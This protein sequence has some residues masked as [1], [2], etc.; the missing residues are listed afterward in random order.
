MIGSHWRRMLLL[1][2]GVTAPLIFGLFGLFILPA[3]AADSAPIP[4][5][6]LSEKRILL[7]YSYHPGF[8]TS[9]Q[10]L[11][12]IR[13]VFGPDGPDVDIEY[14]DAKRVFNKQSVENFVRQLTYKM[15]NLP[16]Y[17]LVMTAD[18]YALRLVLERTDELFSNL[19]VVFF[20]VNNVDL[21]L[22]QNRNPLVTGVV[23]A[24]SF[25][26][27]LALHSSL[28]EER[29]TLN[30]LVDST[31]SGQAD[32]HSL[33]KLVSEFDN[34]NFQVL[35]LAEMDWSQLAEK[36]ALLDKQDAILFLSA[37]QDVNGKTR[38]FKES[39]DFVLNRTEVP[40]WHL[41][42]H[43]VGQGMLGGVLIS[44]YEQGRSA[45]KMA[46][47]VLM[48]EN[49]AN[50]AVLER[51]PN[52]PVF[53]YVLLN[54]YGMDRSRL[55]DSSVILNEPTTIWHIYKLEILL[56][57]VLLSV[58][59]LFTAWLIHKNRQLVQAQG[60]LQSSQDKLRTLSA[61]VEQSPLPVV[62]TSP[63]AF[64]EYVNE[65]FSITTG[66]PTTE[67]IGKNPRIISSG[68]TPRSTY[69]TLWK[70]ISA[71]R[72]WRGELL[73]GRRNG[74]TYWARCVICPVLDERGKTTHYFSIHE[75]ISLQKEQAEK[76]QYQAHY[77]AL[78]DLP[79]RFLVLDRLSQAIHEGRR[80]SLKFALLFIDLDE[81]KTI[82][83]T[84]GHETGDELLKQVARRL[85]LL[86]RKEDTV[87]RLGGD[88]F[89]LI[90]RD[91][92]TAADA[93]PVA[94]NV[95]K[96]FTDV[97]LLN[98]R[99]VAV[100]ASIGIAIFPEDGQDTTILLSKADIAMYAAKN[101]GRNTFTYYSTTKR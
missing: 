71:G 9:P 22:A 56:G 55:P 11:E 35:S 59:I 42:E 83:D 61:A 52:V 81:F 34:L 4:E 77:D 88:E 18:D 91:L 96:A 100:T 38:S 54:K 43:G 58:L 80:N 1:I 33:M 45:A 74:N 90:I 98:E 44:H 66:F 64:I 28:L 47:Q 24:S 76:I 84:L 40:V 50:I 30:V 25:K 36:L 62:I 32:L 13:S 65:A 16:P 92:H 46:R 6:R 95:L 17:D 12:G 57:L 68:Q 14:M 19:P 10:S 79:N 78:T 23:E 85:S 15:Q 37:Y 29:T 48:G 41:W 27:T 82:N 73:N 87:G 5:S 2:M 86:I 67:V 26:E 3:R 97:F 39:L 93:E 60:Q 99:E 20:G 75:D 72:I 69:E 49:P 53:D 101:A 70:T 31:L 7:I 8:P 89:V 21:A 94:R 51:S 63:N